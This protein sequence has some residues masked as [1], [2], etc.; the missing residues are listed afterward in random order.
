MLD[1]E[2]LGWVAAALEGGASK[3]AVCR[4]F[5]VA[6]SILLDSLPRAGWAGPTASGA[7]RGAAGSARV[8]GRDRPAGLGVG[9][10]AGS[11]L[12]WVSR[13]GS[14]EDDRRSVP[15]AGPH[16]VVRLEC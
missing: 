2:R 9:R 1:A 13:G 16:R 8:A 11:H 12:A 3:A 15:V 10:R 5:R 6:R 14:L 7:G 4:A